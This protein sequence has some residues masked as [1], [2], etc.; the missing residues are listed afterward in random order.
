MKYILNEK[1]INT[2][3]IGTWAWGTGQN[4]GKIVFGNSYPEQQLIE[5][6]DTAFAHGFNFWDT[7]EVY[8]NGTSEIL[9]G[10]LIKN[11]DVTVSTK[12]FPNKKYKNG[13]NR[14]ALTSS[15][16]RLG[17]ERVDLYWLHSPKNI[18]HNMKEL[19]QLQK[20]G[21][22]GSVGLSNGNVEQIRLADIVLRENGS[23]LTAVQNHYSL[24]SVERE[25]EILEYCIKNHILFFGYM[26]LEQGALSGHYDAEHHF[27]SFSMR[28]LSFG[29][30]KFRKIQQ[31]IDYIRVLGTKYNVDPSQ[32]PTAWAISKEVIPIVGLT[33]PEHAR[34][35]SKGINTVLEPHE[36]RQLE[37]LAINS[38]VKCRGMWE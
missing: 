6:F 26:I 7:A 21:L 36:I 22:I 8:G 4:G 29:K 18:E 32:I 31:L 1:E 5:T 3:M 17:L 37:Q 27:P 14:I 11:K 34:S 33:K 9:L 23:S 10:G 19:A 13:E 30:S 2:C 38:G 35:L 16:S 25:A 20:E 15:L 28:G 12:H 24:L